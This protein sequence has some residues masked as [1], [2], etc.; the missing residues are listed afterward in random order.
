MRM[1]TPSDRQPV[2]SSER[3]VTVHPPVRDP[4]AEV[5]LGLI[6]VLATTAH[7]RLRAL[8][9]IGLVVFGAGAV[10][11]QV[12]PALLGRPAWERLVMGGLC[13]FLSVVSAGVWRFAARARPIASTSITVGLAYVAVAALAMAVAEVAIGPTVSASYDGIPGMCIW[14]V[15]FPLVIPCLPSQALVTAL[16][17]AATLPAAYLV[18]VACGR[19]PSDPQVL[20]RWFSPGFFCAGVAFAAAWVFA[21][22]AGDLA[23]ARRE[24]RDLGAYQLEERLASG[25]M[26]EVWRARHR[27][28]PRSAAVKFIRPSGDLRP[29][30]AATSELASRFEREA[31]AIALLRSPHTVQLYDFGINPDGALFYAMELL[32]G[33]D[34]ESLVARHGPLPEARA[35]AIIAQ[36]CLSLAEAHGNGLVHRDVKPGNLM[37]CRLG[38]DL[39]VVKVLDFGLVGTA[40]QA[41][42]VAAGPGTQT[43]FAGTPGY[44]A[45]ELIFGSAPADARSDLYGLGATLYWLLTGSTVF[46]AAGGGEDLVA[47]SMDRPRPPG[48]RGGRVFHPDL[49]ALVLE[50]LAKRPEQRPASALV[51]R[52]R[53]R[54]I[55]F[56]EAWDD[57]RIRTWW[58][59]QGC[60]TS[61]KRVGS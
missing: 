42:P 40:Q 38:E 41:V 21:R 17:C 45:P 6:E 37:L 2:I 16:G 57:A 47:H 25:G 44:I 4:G 46:P 11:A 5:R 30:R 28:L 53:L 52:E 39:E 14:I 27:L 35:A 58:A 23:R 50:C 36:A 60:G 12:L 61:A 3:P 55:V 9:V 49:E 8:A 48:E 10:I 51:V 20:L 1:P 15:L 13:A 19:P 22:L 54:A 34:L 56:G 29:D 32:D 18:A 43:G 24:V 26:G 31:R 7:A 59:D 33:I